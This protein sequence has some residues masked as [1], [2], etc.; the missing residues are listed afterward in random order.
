MANFNRK[1]TSWNSEIPWLR[2]FTCETES[3]TFYEMWF[4]D[5]LNAQIIAF[6]DGSNNCLLGVKVLHTYT[7]FSDF[8]TVEVPKYWACT[9]VCVRSCDYT[10]KNSSFCYSILKNVFESLLHERNPKVRWRFSIKYLFILWL[11]YWYWDDLQAIVVFVISIH[12]YAF[13]KSEMEEVGMVA[14][15]GCIWLQAFVVTLETKWASISPL[16]FVMF[17]TFLL[18]FRQVK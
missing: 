8:S 4:M 12:A 18:I 2:M 1:W 9:S 10:I 11:V 6:S 16:S 17:E 3:T 5:L 13:E 15:S 14:L 7:S